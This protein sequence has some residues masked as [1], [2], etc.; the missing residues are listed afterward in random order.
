MSV[1]FVLLRIFIKTPPLTHRQSESMARPPV[2]KP[3]A[4][5]NP[6][7]GVTTA[8]MG[9]KSADGSLSP[10]KEGRQVT[11]TRGEG[12]PVPPLGHRCHKYTHNRVCECVCARAGR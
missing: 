6:L 9:E 4:T 2:P 3:P 1:I 5:T 11:F 7:R 12:S 10:S 8:K